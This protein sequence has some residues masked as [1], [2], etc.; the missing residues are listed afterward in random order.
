MPKSDLPFGSEFSPSQVGLANVLELA[1]AHGG[2]WRAFEKA[3][4]IEYFE[5]HKTSDYN[6][7]K[8]ANNT[9]LGMQAYGIIDDNAKLTD[10][11]EQLYAV[12]SDSKSLYDLLAKHILLNL[13]GS[14]L[15]QCVQ[16]IKPRVR[17]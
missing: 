2:E 1:R 12:R 10:F 14:T 11:G 16:D 3:V 15:V 8:L 17:R 13:H 4:R 9:K 5:K 7:G 6:R